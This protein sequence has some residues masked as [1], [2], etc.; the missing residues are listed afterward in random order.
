M[1]LKLTTKLI[2][3]LKAHEIATVSRIFVAEGPEQIKGRRKKIYIH[4][5]FL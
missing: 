2:K 1:V 5:S 3:R 4:M